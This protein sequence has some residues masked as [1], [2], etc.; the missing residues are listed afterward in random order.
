[1]SWMIAMSIWM[2]A[3]MFKEMAPPRGR[4]TAK[5]GMMPKGFTQ[6]GLLESG[7]RM[8]PTRA[9][10]TPLGPSPTVPRMNDIMRVPSLDEPLAFFSSALSSLPALS[11]S[12]MASPMSASICSGGRVSEYITSSAR[13]SP[14]GSV[15][16]TNAIPSEKDLN[17]MPGTKLTPMPGKPRAK[18]MPISSEKRSRENVKSIVLSIS[19]PALATR[20][21]MGPSITSD[22]WN[23]S[24]RICIVNLKM[25]WNSARVA[26]FSV[27][28][29]KPGTL[30]MSNS[31][32]TNVRCPRRMECVENWMLNSFTKSQMGAKTMSMSEPSTAVVST[33]V[34][35]SGARETSTSRTRHS[36]KH[37]NENLAAMNS[38]GSSST[39]R[40]M[41][42]KPNS[43]PMSWQPEVYA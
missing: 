9:M 34:G 42:P 11:A 15:S 38:M 16:S 23:A 17:H 6:S 31:Q 20:P 29:M 41:K 8:A 25:D 18:E 1:M 26:S 12:K 33:H 2:H 4:P 43:S 32:P 35:S 19:T 13:T 3:W 28:E 21:A 30:D 5:R 14:A 22:S 40:I 39:S 7:G 36:G 10:N 27:S 37:P 24:S